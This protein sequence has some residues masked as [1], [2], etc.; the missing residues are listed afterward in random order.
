MPNARFNT[1]G[2]LEETDW[3]QC[4]DILARASYQGPFTLVASDPNDI[5]GGIERQAAFLRDNGYTLPEPF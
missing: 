5:W 3:R 2:S 4:L 1:D